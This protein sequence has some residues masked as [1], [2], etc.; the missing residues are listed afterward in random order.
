MDVHLLHKADQ[1][2]IDQVAGALRRAGATVHRLASTDAAEIPDLL[3]AAAPQRVIVA[4]GDGMIHHVAQFAVPAQVGIGV[5][6]GGSGNDVARAVGL[7]RRIAAAAAVALGPLRSLDVI[8]IEAVGDATPVYAVSVLT[9]GFSGVVNDLANRTAWPG[10][11]AKYTVATIRSLGR[12][13]S[14]R[15]TGM[16]DLPEEISLIA[17]GNTRCFGGGMAICPTAS[18]TDGVLDAT[19]VAAVHPLH[20]AVL[21]PT[22]FTGQHVRSRKV[23]TTRFTAATVDIDA[24]W[25]AD[26]EPLGVTGPVVVSVAGAALP[27]ASGL[28]ARG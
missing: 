14:Y 26:G 21:L 27:F 11:Q 15:L 28:D 23:S 13:R 5:M 24:G 4:G 17:I 12:L 3:S 20:L 19:A 7:P 9:A 16:H 18:P 25:W 2:G 8:R 22:A 1:S 10:R 6:P